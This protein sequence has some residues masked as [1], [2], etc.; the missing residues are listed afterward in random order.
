MNFFNQKKA[1]IKNLWEYYNP[2][3]ERS[4]TPVTEELLSQLSDPLSE[5]LIPASV[6]STH[7]QPPIPLDNWLTSEIRNP[8]IAQLGQELPPR[9]LIS[10]AETC[11]LFSKIFKPDIARKRLMHH[12]VCGKQAEAEAMLE[13]V[14]NDP[15]KLRV[16][17]C[18]KVGEVNDLSGKPIKGLT[19]FQ[20]ALCAGDVAHHPGEINMCEMFKAYFEKL[21]DGLE[22]MQKQ[23]HE[24][25]PEGFPEDENEDPAHVVSQK[26]KAQ[27]VK[28]DVLTPL[29]EAIIAASDEQ[30]VEML[31]KKKTTSPLGKAFDLFRNK[32]E[33]ISVEDQVFNFN[34][35]LEALTLY[36]E[37]FDALQSW[38]KRA[39]F[40][41]QGIGFIQRCSPACNLQA[42]AQ[43]LFGIVHDNEKLSRSFNFK[44]VWTG[45]TRLRTGPVVSFSGLGFDY[46]CGGRWAA[47][48][49]AGGD[50]YGLERT[51]LWSLRHFA[52]FSRFFSNKNIG[53]IKLYAQLPDRPS[54]RATL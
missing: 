35:F 29:I 47:G 15:Q 52:S 53:L 24:I 13:A 18:G 42:Y 30:A 17:L 2:P 43:G 8:L 7:K 4:P 40:C 3:Q 54:H 36:D 12:V 20:A 31:E 14:K 45:I 25:F 41:S 37:Q 46:C 44:Y 10:L 48:G 21:P 38:N 22:V 9:D 50:A 23:I 16:S 28:Q 49:L 33:K 26:E 32:M 19:A 39:L 34:Y 5:P 1:Q 6:S 27:E 11:S 51:E